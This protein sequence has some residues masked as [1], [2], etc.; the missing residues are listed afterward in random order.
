VKSVLHGTGVSPQINRFYG[1]HFPPTLVFF[2]AVIAK[3]LA[4]KKFSIFMEP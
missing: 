3:S 4:V 1:N 2:L